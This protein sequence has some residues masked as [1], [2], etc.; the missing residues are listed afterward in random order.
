MQK[1]YEALKQGEEIRNNLI[2]LK[3]MLKEEGALDAYLS[4]TEDDELIASFLQ[5]NDA[6]IRKNAAVIL[7]LLQSQESIEK[8]WDAYLSE[9]QLFVKS[10]YLAAMQKLDC[11]DYED[12]LKERYQQLLDY[13][14]GEEDLKHI[15]E[16]LKELRRIVIQFDGGIT[17]HQFSGYEKPQ[18]FIL[19]TIKN[20]QD[21][22]SVQLEHGRTKI[23][24]MGVQ[25][26]GGDIR[27]A[28]NIRTYRELLFTLRCR[29]NLPLE[30]AV[31]AR[32]LAQSD[33]ARIL[34][35]LH[36]G[37]APFYFRLEVK[38]TMP[39]DK[40]SA[41]VKK[42]A[43]ELEQRTR[44]FLVNSAE[45]YEAEIRLIEN[46]AGGFYPCLKL[47]TLPMKRF[48]YRKYA[49][50]SS[51]HPSTAALLVELA[52]N[53]LTDYA[54]VMDAFC[55]TAALLMERIYALPVRT[56]Y[57][58]DTFE[59]AIN[60]ARENAA[61]AH[62]NI[63]FIRRDFMDFTHSCPFDEIWA[64]MPVRGKKTKE[65]Q[66]DL[67]QAFFEKAKSLLNEH[68][69]IFLYGNEH[70]F[71]KKHLRLQEAELQLKQEFC[72]RE[73][74]GTYFYII[75]KTHAAVQEER[76]EEQAEA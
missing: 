39:F 31:V 71:V 57:A 44:H 53:W 67:Y 68:G 70:G 59:D 23:I 43:A 2:E 12:R 72:I 25:A 17:R 75:E 36:E 65:E 64:D 47:Y 7:G 4:M 20:Y 22:T 9:T 16:E 19:T 14:P 45:H 10:A 37:D 50:A 29:K 61:I 38:S 73:K 13:E 21:T 30:P 55:G 11:R 27:E 56:A 24:P 3:R 41:F 48:S 69:R 74:R 34:S 49:T 6:K 58:V 26:I 40:K 32:E 66:D 51:M 54:R 76:Q 15:Q 35:E 1:V 63:N 28:L 33:L 46:R 62:M 5:E 18:N 52:S 60:G 42:T 8:L